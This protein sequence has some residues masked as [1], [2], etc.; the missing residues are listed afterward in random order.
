MPA[1]NALGT[2]PGLTAA[3]GTLGAQL[4]SVPGQQIVTLTAAMLNAL[5]A[6]TEGDIKLFTLP[7]KH[8]IKS[9]LAVVDVA[10]AGADV[11]TV[12]GTV[13]RTSA[14]YADYFP[15]CSLMAAANTVYGN[16]GTVLGANLTGQ[17]LV[18][19][20]A[21]TDFYVH[22]V[23]TTGAAADMTDVTNLVARYIVELGMIP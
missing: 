14:A 2:L 22:A 13:G 21:A 7:A 9:L 5:G 3:T 6:V 20:A 16:A 12:T 18:S 23:M 11:S 8:Y 17:D 4:N 1:A 15:A 10:A 19:Y